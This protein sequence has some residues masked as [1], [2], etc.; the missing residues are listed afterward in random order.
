[1]VYL[2]YFKSTRKFYLCLL[3][4]TL[5]FL[6][7]SQ[8]QS[9]NCSADYNTIMRIEDSWCYDEHP[10]GA[11]IITTQNR[12]SIYKAEGYPAVEAR[13]SNERSYAG[14]KSLKFAYSNGIPQDMIF[15][16]ESS[17]L[18]R[19]STRVFI[20]S[21]RSAKFAML[22]KNNSTMY[23]IIFGADGQAAVFKGNSLENPI[24]FNY[25]QNEWFKLSILSNLSEQK[26]Y[27]FI[28]DENIAVI[29]NLQNESIYFNTY[30]NLFGNSLYLLENDLFYLDNLCYSKQSI[31]FINCAAIVEPVCLN[32]S[33]LEVGGNSCYA[34]AKGFLE[35]EFKKCNDYGNICELAMP[36]ICGQ[37]ISSSTIGETYKFYRPDYGSCLPQNGSN[38]FNAPDKIFKFTKTGNIGDVGIHLFGKT[39]GVD[40]DVFLLKKCGQTWRGDGD[41]YTVTDVPP[42]APNNINI[43]CIASGISTINGTYDDD[44]INVKNLPAGEYYIVVDGQKKA[45]D[46][47]LSLTCFDLSCETSREIFC[48]TP[49]TNQNN[50]NGYNEVSVY[51]SPPAQGSGNPDNLPKGTGCT[52][53]ELLYRY[54]A[55]VTQ[56]ITI[57][58]NGIASNKDLNLFLLNNCDH[59]VCLA[60]STNSA[61]KNEELKYIVQAGV[62]Y[63]IAVDGYKGSTS[64]FNIEVKCCSSTPVY[65][66]C[67]N[68]GK[69][70]HYYSGDGISLRY[71]FK[72][73]QTIPSGNNW[74]IRDEN[75]T[76]LTTGT[77]S[78]IAY[79][80]PKSGFYEVC[81]PVVNSSECVEYCC[82]NVWIEN[83]F[84]CNIIGCNFD[85]N[86]NTYVLN[87]S[88]SGQNGQFLEL[89]SGEQEP[90]LIIDSYVPPTQNCRTRIFCYRYFDGN[91]WRFCCKR[92]YICD[93]ISCGNS[94][95]IQYNFDNIS[96]KFDFKL[97]DG[98]KYQDVKWYASGTPEIVLGNGSLISWYPVQG[99]D[100][101]NYNICVKYFDPAVNAER[102]CCKKVFVCDPYKC[103]SI[104]VKYKS[105]TN[106]YT[107]SMPN[108]NAINHSWEMVLNNTSLGNNSICTYIPNPELNCNKY[109]FCVKYREGDVWKQ[110]CTY[111]SLCNPTECGEQIN[112]SY[113]NGILNLSTTT[114]FTNVK[115]Y[116]D[117]QNINASS[118]RSAGTY[119]VCCIYFDPNTKAFKVCCKTIVLGNENSGNKLTFDLE[120]NVCGPI[121]GLLEIPIKVK[122]FKDI[123]S[124]QFSVLISDNVAKIEDII[125]M[126]LDG[127]FLSSVNDD[128]TATVIWNN[129]NGQ[130]LN[131]NTVVAIVKLKLLSIFPNEKP[132]VFSNEPTNIVA[133]NTSGQEI[134]TETINGSYCV[135]NTDIKICGTVITENGKAVQKTSIKAVGPVSKSTTTDTNGKYCFENL[136]AGNYVITAEK[137]ID[138]KSGVNS[139]D[140][141]ALKK[142][143]LGKTKLDS[144]Y[145]ILAGDTKVNKSVNSGDVSE[146]QKLIL[147]KIP[148]FSECQSW[149]FIDKQFQFSIPA[150]PFSSEPKA[151]LSISDNTNA[152]DFIGIKMG[153]V[154][155]SATGELQNVVT[156][157]RSVNSITVVLEPKKLSTNKYLLDVKI[158]D[159]IDIEAL[160]F[161]LNWNPGTLKFLKLNS[162]S[163]TL[164]LDEENFNTSIN[165]EFG[166]IW[167]AA[168]ALSLSNNTLLF[169]LEL[170]GESNISDT[171]L[172]KVS[173]NPIDLYC[174]DKLGEELMIL[175]EYKMLTVPTREPRHRGYFVQPNPGP[176]IFQSELFISSNGIDVFDSV[177]RLVQS[178]LHGENGS[179]D[180]QSLRNGTYHL[181]IRTQKEVFV[182]KVIVFK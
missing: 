94:D 64:N 182:Q 171:A 4:I 174:Q 152:A 118:S 148:A 110:C 140:I 71:T 20:P 32:G 126:N 112:Y 76:I 125:K 147:A 70:N 122:N 158:K 154:N 119:K 155:Q 177:G 168:D 114:A 101:K 124:F 63:I 30:A 127:D 160:Q 100:C 157:Q 105:N 52:A 28:N 89:N 128:K 139:G 46:F 180:L 90:S 80:F 23:R 48:N 130:T 34:I 131:D 87:S 7:Q 137:D 13:V 41:I 79:N 138:D 149:T 81:F 178:D 145:N 9:C 25:K 103:S 132:I 54:K 15:K 72:Y 74:Q 117:D 143:I 6:R 93:P 12:W 38:D 27:L 85:P 43:E 36:I 62:T 111:V 115:W 47:D 2:Q 69:I 107:F 39:P 35:A 159:F 173:G 21:G 106:E 113:S 8:G 68:D 55:T 134:P 102:I 18:K 56:E 61:G 169:Q 88:N 11:S 181:R 129:V 3:L 37:T 17:N 98:S 165:G 164:K 42:D 120:N 108:V 77:S 16:M 141:S 66:H 45:G 5:F 29:S 136:P 170:E 91:Y 49:L 109:D 92:V 75:K 123:E 40:L 57:S 65:K 176:G 1:M 73:N 96:G 162:L 151:S 166:F 153:D 14:T 84:S 156:N 50:G 97:K 135:G 53:P 144:P 26:D 58:M 22:D 10:I 78:T 60:S 86:A 150:N 161:S 59:T 146:I 24:K 31:L 167:S 179:L 67:N 121:N 172:I 133:T 83:P 175:S 104:D 44:F 142:H 82:Y 99:Q 95:D 116:I 33:N 163:S 51:C 19:V